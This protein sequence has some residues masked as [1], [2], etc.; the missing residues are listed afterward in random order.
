[1]LQGKIKNSHS[2]KSIKPMDLDSTTHSSLFY[3]QA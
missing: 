2:T 1:M 3:A